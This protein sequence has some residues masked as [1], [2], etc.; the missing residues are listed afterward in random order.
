MTCLTL[1]FGTGVPVILVA[2]QHP[3]FI[4]GPVQLNTW[5]Q[6]RSAIEVTWQSLCVLIQFNADGIKLL[7]RSAHFGMTITSPMT[8]ENETNSIDYPC[9][10][11]YK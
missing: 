8:R 11:S 9:M 2:P 3:T 6:G 10:Y 4:L 7:S 1:A 5:K